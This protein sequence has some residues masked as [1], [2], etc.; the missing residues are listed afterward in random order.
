MSTSEIESKLNQ[1]EREVIL[2]AS[3]ICHLAE[4]IETGEPADLQAAESTMMLGAVYERFQQL[5][6]ASL[7]PLARKPVAIVQKILDA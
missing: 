5:H 6:N 3:I 4:H 1:A 2:M 7:L